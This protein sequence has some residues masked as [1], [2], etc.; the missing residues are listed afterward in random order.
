MYSEIH[1]MGKEIFFVP[2]MGNLLLRC[3]SVTKDVIVTEMAVP[4]K[5]VPYMDEML[6]E[7]WRKK[8]M[9]EG[10]G[11]YSMNEFVKILCDDAMS[12]KEQKHTN[13]GRNIFDTVCAKLI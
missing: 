4:K 12:Q 5:L 2:C 1:R 10:Q 3:N 7:N 13:Y 6:S 9:L 8:Y 11:A